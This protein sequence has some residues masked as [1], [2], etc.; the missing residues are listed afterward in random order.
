MG[1]NY[2]RELEDAARKMILVHRPKTLIQLI[3][4]MIVNKVKIR[5]AG[6]LLYNNKLN[7]YILTV[8]RGKVGLKI[9]TGFIRIDTDNAMIK[10]FMDKTNH[11]YIDGGVLVYNKISRMLRNRYLLRKHKDL[12]ELLTSLR[13]QMNLLEAVVAIPSYF[14][15]ELLGVLLLGKKV[16]GRN[17]HHDELD[18]FVALAHDVA[19][20]I[21]NAQLFEELQGQ[22]ER[23]K[24]LFLETTKALATTIDAKDHYTRG[25]TER[26]TQIS[27]SL[28]KK[29]IITE[30]IKVDPVFLDDLNISALL[31][32][33]GKIGIPEHILNKK[34]ELNE[35]ERRKIN[36]HP[37]IGAAILE[38][39]EDLKRA[40]DGVKYHHERFDGRGYPEGLKGDR[41]PL[42]SS[43][44][45]V[46]DSY[47]AM[48]TSR[49]YR[50]ALNKKQA[51]EEI[52]K[53]IDTQFQPVAAKALIE[54]Y[55]E[56]CL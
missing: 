15:N 34:G 3:V 11:R 54:L 4:R 55:E 22:I 51:V 45:A 19:M 33:I 20:A 38:P 52:R 30:R 1:I 39:I 44:I 18:F 31:H 7:S 43:I 53:C 46:A 35:E 27:L 37:L 56:G 36:E 8:S 42:I 9:P 28:A 24:R 49:P 29:L 41:I 21:R 47:D 48:T 32:D 25:H 6:I 13:T 17:F 16:S 14:Q 12:R 40:I 10:F 26:V 23:N 5:H 2:K 50:P